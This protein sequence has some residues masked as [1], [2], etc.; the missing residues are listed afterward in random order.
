MKN[1]GYLEKTIF[2]FIPFFIIFL[3]DYLYLNRVDFDLIN[4]ETIPLFYGS[5]NSF[6][7]QD[8]DNIDRSLT[9]H[10]NNLFNSF[11]II[12][13]FFFE[14]NPKNYI[15][16]SKVSVYFNFFFILINGLIVS[17][18]SKYVEISNKKIFVLSLFCATIPGVIIFTSLSINGYYSF[19]AIL[20]PL[21]LS[22]YI[23][24]NKNNFENKIVYFSIIFFGFSI[25]I[26]YLSFLII[27]PVILIFFV[28]FFFNRET[29]L[30]KKF[31]SNKKMLF[32]TISTFLF[33]F[34]FFFFLIRILLFLISFHLF[35]ENT[36][37]IY[38]KIDKIFYLI[39]VFTA[40]II[41]HNFFLIIKP[42]RNYLYS[43]LFYFSIGW[44]IGSNILFLGWFRSFFLNG[45]LRGTD[46][47][48]IYT[49]DFFKYFELF[50]KNFINLNLNYFLITLSLFFL[51]YLFKN[52][53]IDFK[54]LIYLYLV[55]F[56]TIFL[57]F[58]ILLKDN[59]AINFNRYLISLSMIFIYLTFIRKVLIYNKIIFCIIFITIFSNY[60]NYYSSVK[61]TNIEVKKI[62]NQ[63]ETIILNHLKNFPESKIYCK[64]TFIPSSICGYIFGEYLIS[65]RSNK[66]YVNNSNIKF[67]KSSIP[68]LDKNDLMI[69]GS[70][71]F[72]EGNVL[73]DWKRDQGDFSI[74][75][76]LKI[77]KMN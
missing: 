16:F 2:F 51:V 70:D 9:H 27:I 69:T 3:A 30:I 76:F 15:I 5:S 25:N 67:I 35:G 62:N 23:L 68:K 22:S 44:F 77:V 55:F 31:N 10:P 34:S 12:F 11:S 48:T 26:S 58:D 65:F 60:L 38:H 24:L 57:S 72:I 21:T 63:S 54:N 14:N 66:R 39:I 20:L 75:P 71:F 28:N 37:F 50:K 6:F 43:Y 18:F 8:L 61:E 64:D 33:I 56:T 42:L 47:Y 32:G 73:F 52:K 13:F 17:F 74:K 36:N 1:F 46:S 41:F 19:G 40:S 49:G 59:E 53:K 29:I 7:Y 45:F 4:G